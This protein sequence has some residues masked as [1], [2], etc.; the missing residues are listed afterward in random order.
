MPKEL[1]VFFIPFAVRYFN[2]IFIA[3]ALNIGSEH[4]I[5]SRVQTVWCFQ[6]F[7]CFSV[8]IQFFSIENCVL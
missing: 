3:L 8:F 1:R 2:W 5:E 4:D 7:S 6:L